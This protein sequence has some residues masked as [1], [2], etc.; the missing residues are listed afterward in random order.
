MSPIQPRDKPLNL[1]APGVSNLALAN[2]IFAVCLLVGGGLLLVTVFLGDLAGAFHFGGD[3]GGVSLLPVLLGFVSMFGVGGLFATGVFHLDAGP[4]SLVG[5]VS[6]IAGSGL[7][8]GLFNILR[9]SEGATAFSLADLVG[10]TGRV[11]VG[12][13]RH[14]FGSVMLRYAGQSMEMTATADVEVAAG[15]TVRVEAVAGN[16]LVVAPLGAGGGES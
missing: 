9:K 2:S 16:N 11:S 5:A 4:A 14:H 7:V 13:P 15:T 12:I 1:A 3:V 10:Q 8:F 6:G